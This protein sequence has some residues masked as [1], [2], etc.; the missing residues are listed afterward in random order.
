MDF[1]R[2]TSDVDKF[3]SADVATADGV[4]WLNDT[5]GFSPPDIDNNPLMLHEL[6][7]GDHDSLPLGDLVE[8]VPPNLCFSKNAAQVLHP[9]LEQFGVFYDVSIH[10]TGT[11]HEFVGYY[12]NEGIDCL[13]QSMSDIV[14]FND[15]KIMSIKSAV[16]D[17]KKI[18][19]NCDIFKIVGM[20]SFIVVSDK[21]RN[22]VDRNNLRGFDFEVLRASEEKSGA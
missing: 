2:L 22:A 15:G 20:E 5:A 10:H 19:Q 4:R 17:A 3:A 9:D 11:V 8:F 6:C 12:V 18:D 14:R 13:D 1:F 21:I 7:E 16:I